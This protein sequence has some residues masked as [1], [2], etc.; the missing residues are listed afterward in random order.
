[1]RIDGF[2]MGT[3]RRHSLFAGISPTNTIIC[4]KTNGGGTIV[5]LTTYS[6]TNYYHAN[7]PC[8]NKATHNQ[9]LVVFS[10]QIL[11]RTRCRTLAQMRVLGRA[12]ALRKLSRTQQANVRRAQGTRGRVQPKEQR[13]Y[14]DCCTAGAIPGRRGAVGIHHLSGG[15]NLCHFVETP[16]LLCR[17]SHVLLASLRPCINTASRSMHELHI[18][19]AL[20]QIVLARGRRLLKGSGG[21]PTP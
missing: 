18:F 2:A 10:C 8:R 12:H 15:T 3:A 11:R 13:G 20:P 14:V 6:S 16:F 19:I 7:Y 1:M 9:I 5:Q 21:V 17:P 4:T